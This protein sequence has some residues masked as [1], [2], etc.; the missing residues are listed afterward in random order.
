MDRRILS[1]II[2]GALVLSANV[3]VL[4]EDIP[5]NPLAGQDDYETA[6]EEELTE[7]PQY[8]EVEYEPEGSAQ[9]EE[10][11][12]CYEPE[13]LGGGEETEIT[14]RSVSTDADGYRITATGPFPGDVNFYA[15][16]KD[17]TGEENAVKKVKESLESS[18][19]SVMIYEVFDI[20]LRDGEENVWQPAEHNAKVRIRIEGLEE[21]IE[22][23]SDRDVEGTFDILSVQRI[24]DVTEEIEDIPAS[25]EDNDIVF[26]ADHFTEYV[27]GVVTYNT[28]GAQRPV[29]SNGS[30]ADYW[31]ADGLD[32]SEEQ[33]GS[34]RA[35]FFP[36]DRTI[37]VAR[38]GGNG[39]IKDYNNDVIWTTV[40][41]KEGD[42]WHII[43]LDV[44][45]LV[46]SDGITHVGKRAF[47]GLKTGEILLPE[48]LESI[49]DEAF[50]DALNWYGCSALSLPSSLTSIGYKAFETVNNAITEILGGENIS[51]VG[52]LAFNVIRKDEITEAIPTE[53]TSPSQ[54]ML[55]YDWAGSKRSV[56]SIIEVNGE[57]YNTALATD[58]WDVSK[59]GDGSVTAYWFED[60]DKLVIKGAG[61]MRDFD[62]DTGIDI[63]SAGLK[64]SAFFLVPDSDITEIG[65]TTFNGYSMMSLGT[66]LPESLES[67]GE[68]AFYG[69]SSL[70]ITELPAGLCA[71]G[72]N[73]FNKCVGITSIIYTGGDTLT[74]RVLRILFHVKRE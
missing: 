64:A 73:A 16:K 42:S 68:Y 19:L 12:E 7:A 1:F 37:L 39:R 32:M 35:F 27:I 74:S 52:R 33:D 4:A 58:S 3:P 14:E 17:Y 54:A 22:D 61:A 6:V 43:G 26:E 29:K 46:F 44:D 67:I 25:S 21:V 65:S 72:N 15:H 71:I 11:P 38:D 69:C 51:E 53:M 41:C 60:S 9:N 56:A 49:D 63:R 50:F 13:V 55:D 59:A 45:K 66:L 8:R 47:Y 36:D 20:E 10:M 5:G 48:T 70:E 28:E 24:N 31:G 34:I 30:Y 23:T 2:S 40:G 62:A 18:S 57:R